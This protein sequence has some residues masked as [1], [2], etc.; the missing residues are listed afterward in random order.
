MSF[1]TNVISDKYDDE[2]Y[3]AKMTNHID[4]VNASRK[5]FDIV[6]DRVT[7]DIDEERKKMMYLV[8]DS[9]IHDETNEEYDE[10]IHNMR[11][12]CDY[13]IW[14]DIITKKY[15]LW[16]FYLENMHFDTNM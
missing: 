16:R 3:T 5:L 6:F 11:L 7:N 15:D 1:N 13:G 8:I 4:H 9:K 14:A 10:I 12:I 2:S